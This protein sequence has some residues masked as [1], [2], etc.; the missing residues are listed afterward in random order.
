M[1]RSE[2]SRFGLPADEYPN[3][4]HF[5]W[6]LY[7]RQGRRIIGE[8]VITEHDSIPS[9]GRSRPHIEKDTICTYEHRFDCHPS[10]NRGGE[11]SSAFAS[12]GFELV[13]GTIYFR[14]RL[15]SPNRPA[16]VPYRAIVPQKVDALLV[17]AALSATHVAFTAIRMEPV[18]MAAGQAAGVAAALAI[19][20][21]ITPREVNTSELQV[22][23]IRQGQVLVYFKGLTANDP[24]FEDIQLRAVAED[25]PEFDLTVL[26]SEM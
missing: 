24:D 18:W 10:R 12:D 13:E 8:A 9:P 6:Q 15:T 1:P 14:N 16:T 23:L 7:V 2:A 3:D 22:K 11:G 5:P 20:Q 4:D 25:Y 26:K 17:P 19:S 21:G